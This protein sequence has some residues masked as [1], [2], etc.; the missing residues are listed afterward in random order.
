MRVG[1]SIWSI[2]VHPEWD[3]AESLDRIVISAAETGGD[4]ELVSGLKLDGAVSLEDLES[5]VPA[6][7]Q[8]AVP[9]RCGAFSGLRYGG[10][11]EGLHT[12]WW[13]LSSGPLRLRVFF[14]GLP[15]HSAT[16]VAQAQAM[17]STLR[18]DGPSAA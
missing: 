15:R 9:A 8:P 16:E 11:D 12:V 4:L 17:L 14:N 18:I 5:E 2:Q 3:A 1:L 7:W 10:D 6:R 13:A